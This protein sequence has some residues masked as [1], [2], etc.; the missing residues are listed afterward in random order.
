MKTRKA[1]ETQ[2]TDVAPV[3]WQER[4]EQLERENKAAWRL[5]M[6]QHEQRQR[7]LAKGF[8]PL[9]SGSGVTQE[10]TQGPGEHRKRVT[11]RL[12]KDER[13]Y[14]QETRRKIEKFGDAAQSLAKGLAGELAGEIQADIFPMAVA[15]DSDGRVLV[16]VLPHKEGETFGHKSDP[17]IRVFSAF[18]KALKGYGPI[19]NI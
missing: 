18:R 13:A 3:D 14:S 12:H 6:R 19:K 17:F 8:K 7:E 9:L 2:N 5:Q 4:M 1:Q 10:N 16:A 15:G 11:E